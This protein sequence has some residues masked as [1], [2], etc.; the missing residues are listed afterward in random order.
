MRTTAVLG[1]AWGD[2]AKAKI[3]DVLAQDADYIIR[4]QGGNN[5]GHTILT[6]GKQY[7]FHL[8]PSGIL[9]PQKNCVLGPGVVID[10]YKLISEIESL[11]EAGINFENRFFI[12]P[13]AHLVLPIHLELDA[14]QE[15]NQEQISIG[16]TRMGI[17][18]CYADAVARLGVR[19]GDLFQKDY[20]LERLQNIYLHHNFSPEMIDD[21]YTELVNAGQKLKPYLKQIQYL[22][23][24]NGDQRLLFEGAQG[25]LLDVNFGSYPYVTSSHTIAGGIG[26]GCGYFRKVD[27]IIGVFKSYYTRV[28]EGPFP[29]ELFDETGNKIRIQGNEYGSTTGR[30]RRCGWFDAVAAEYAIQINQADEIALTLL[31]VLSGFSEL[32]ICVSYRIAG[33]KL[34]EFPYNSRILSQVEPEF[35]TLPGWNEDISA[36]RTFEALP[37]KAQDYVL[38]IEELLNR[39]ISIIS[40]GADRSQTIFKKR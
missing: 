22:W 16:T 36:T 2:E 40:V 27:R 39:K 3:V 9:Y 38:T 6:D 14:W 37:Q 10:P 11:Q 31:D 18:P 5:A 17:G 26:A 28:G 35:I 15:S 30:P 32:K 19:F 7:I 21:T 23:Q 12:D 25:T 8:I 13:R 1:C 29:T 33:E 20:L 34:T 4:F 24:E